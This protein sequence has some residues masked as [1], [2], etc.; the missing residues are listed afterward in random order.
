MQFSLSVTPYYNMVFLI[1]N[2]GRQMIV[3]PTDHR[4]HSPYTNMNLFLVLPKKISKVLIHNIYITSVMYKE[5]VFDPK[6]NQH[7]IFLCKNTDCTSISFSR[8]YDGLDLGLEG[9]YHTRSMI[10]SIVYRKINFF[11]LYYFRRGC[12]RKCVSLQT[13]V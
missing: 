4:D 11:I 3:I 7:H 6:P 1:V 13:L 2:R 10:R 5:Q 9:H 12:S 8:L